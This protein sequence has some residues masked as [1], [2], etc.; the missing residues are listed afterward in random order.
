MELPIQ[1]T[2]R[3]MTTSD[4]VDAYVRERAAKLDTFSARITGCHVAVEIPHQH[5]R[6]GKHFRVRIDLTV[7]GGEV[8]VSHTPDESSTS[9]D[10]YAAVDHAFDQMGRRLEDHVR[11]QRSEE[12][13]SELQL[14]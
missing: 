1:V 2:F 14:R 10:V 4:A 9:E 5:Q 13:T 7:P 6:S 3:N 12:H 11:R 8:V